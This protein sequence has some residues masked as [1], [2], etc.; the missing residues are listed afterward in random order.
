M[1]C[2]DCWFLGTDGRETKENSKERS[3]LLRGVCV[4]DDSVE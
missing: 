1:N 3:K 2:G 4:G